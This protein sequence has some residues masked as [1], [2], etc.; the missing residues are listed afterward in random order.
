[1]DLQSSETILHPQLIN[2]LKIHLNRQILYYHP[3]DEL[4]IDATNGDKE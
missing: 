4:V 2:H 3:F 1:M